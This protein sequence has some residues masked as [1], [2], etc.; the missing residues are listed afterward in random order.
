M[1]ILGNRPAMYETERR[2][3]AVAQKPRA[4]ATSCL[5]SERIQCLCSGSLALHSHWGGGGR[6]RHEAHTGGG[7]LFP[8]LSLCSR[9]VDTPMSSAV[10]HTGDALLGSGHL[11]NTPRQQ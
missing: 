7:N 1:Q 3:G 11:E 5:V 9:N 6:S 10:N 4:V 8:K 2:E